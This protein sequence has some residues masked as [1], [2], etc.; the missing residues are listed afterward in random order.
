MAQL[1]I[2][3]LLPIP[4]LKRPN[5]LTKL[6]SILGF[7]TYVASFLG[8]RILILIPIVIT[9]GVVLINVFLPWLWI[10]K[11]KYKENRKK[12]K[13]SK[14]EFMME[15]RPYK[16]HPIKSNIMYYI[17]QILIML[18]PFLLYQSILM[19]IGMIIA[20][21][22]TMKIDC[23]GY[24]FIQKIEYQLPFSGEWIVYNGGIDKEDS[25]SWDVIGQRYAYDFVKIDSDKYSSKNLGIELEDYY[26]YGEFLMAPADGTVVK[27]K[28]N[29]HDA[30][31]PVQC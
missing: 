22:R 3:F 26:Y 23:N 5:N 16:R 21:F 28:N 20:E 8:F 6:I 31:N 4:Y 13:E 9:F 30:K 11:S 27:V 19:L 1:F 7:A 17:S 14:D 24:T 15:L 18:N 2:I 25:H 10:D 12:R 29:I